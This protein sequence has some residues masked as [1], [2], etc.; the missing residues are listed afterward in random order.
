MSCLSVRME[1]LSSHWTD[2]HEIWYLGIFRKPVEKIQVSLKLEAKITGTLNE[3]QYTLSIVSHS[4][5]LRMKNI[6]TNV[7]EKLET[8]FHFFKLWRLW[9]NVEKCCR[10]GQA[11]DGNMAHAHWM[12]DVQGHKCIHRVCNTHC[13]STTIM[14]A[15]TRISL[16][17]NAIRV[18]SVLLH[19]RL[20]SEVNVGGREPFSC[21]VTVHRRI[22]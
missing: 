18:L 7:L 16:N 20:H 1:Q 21:F 22:N 12:L 8:Q 4:F 14:A 19:V 10:P 9:A 3:D 17:V 13:F 11:T 15:R 5:L 2:F 6:R